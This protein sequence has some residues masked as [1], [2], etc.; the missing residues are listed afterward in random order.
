M[1]SGYINSVP[2]SV[3]PCYEIDMEGYYI[4]W[5]PSHISSGT[6]RT[7]SST[8][9]F[10]TYSS[11]YF[12]DLESYI[13]YGGF[14]ETEISSAYT[15][16]LYFDPYAFY[17][18]P[19]LSVIQAPYC[20][21]VFYS[22]FMYCSSLTSVSLPTCESVG[23]AAFGECVSLETINLPSCKRLD[24][25]AFEGCTSLSTV[26]LPNCEVIGDF[27]F[28]GTIISDLSL[29]NCRW[30]SQSAFY[31]ASYFNT[32]NVG[33]SY[34]CSLISSNAF[35]GTGITSSTGLIL[36]PDSLYSS[37]VVA[38]Q[39]SYFFNRIRPY[40]W[41]EN[42]IRWTPSD[43]SGY[44]SY[45][46]FS[47][48]GNTYNYS[49]YSGYFSGF[50]TIT[51]SAFINARFTSI[52]T[53][54][55]YIDYRGFLNCSS[56]T[57]VSLP[58]CEYL[59]ISA[60]ANCYNL[61]TV[62]LP[63]CGHIG[64]YCFWRNFPSQY[65]SGL[66]SLTL[67]SSTV[68]E[69]SLQSS[70]ATIHDDLGWITSRQG[71]ICV[72]SSLVSDYK[73]DP[74]WSYY[75][76]RIFP[77]DGQE[78][79][80]SW[81][82]SNISSGT[83]NIGSWDYNFSEYSSGYFS[84]YDSIIIGSIRYNPNTGYSYSSGFASNSIITAIE[85]NA[86][87]ISVGAFANCTSLSYVKLTD[88]KSVLGGAFAHCKS[89][90]SVDLPECELI[91]FEYDG[92]IGVF[93][94]CSALTSISIPKCK[95]IGDGAF[96][97]C[98]ALTGVSLPECSYIGTTAFWGC[99]S[100]SYVYAPSC[101]KLEYKAFQGCSALTNIE[102]PVCSYIGSEAFI[103]AG[104]QTI[105][106]GNS[107][108]CTLSGSRVFAGCPLSGIFVPSDLVNGYKIAPNWSSYSLI[109]YPIPS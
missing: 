13:A 76:N 58:N 44:S 77:I 109:I 15:N 100:L 40:Y 84:M 46:T 53:N 4:K 57:S 59:G 99:R 16:V 10:D 51:S 92:Y 98:S 35:S 94:S 8:Y 54:A 78:Y 14:R 91:G 86:T 30:I 63:V 49:D 23:T 62:N 33:N 69:L 32:I 79:Y 42:Y 107:S 80:I 74:V 64:S 2:F 70:T 52:D 97:V 55:S 102:L 12:F 106:L 73:A 104:L 3:Y 7:Q 88:C 36:V 39:W 75:S 85:T 17:G 28:I 72:P 11:G 25:E 27:A 95:K 90:V 67:G 105:T 22:A 87:T 21:I 38:D 66:F 103:D 18:C 101:L 29:P 89:L 68:C 37:Y 20:S 24:D 71:Y 96:D 48:E 6:F 1:I 65:G 43:Y 50:F 31:G 5:L 41:S 83:F 56:L 60:F 108:I 61:S 93:E 82:P 9:R 45:T 47:I 19:N 34:V 81:T 26:L